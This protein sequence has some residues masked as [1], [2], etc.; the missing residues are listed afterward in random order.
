MPPE[1]VTYCHLAILSWTYTIHH[2]FFTYLKRLRYLT[3]RFDEEISHRELPAFRAA[4]IEKVGREHD[5]FHN[6]DSSSNSVYRYPLVQYKRIGRNPAIICLDAG[7][8][9]IHYL[10]QNRTWSIMVYDRP[11]ELCVKDLRLNQFNLQAWEHTFSFSI[12]DWLGLNQANYERFMAL[13]YEGDRLAFMERILRGNI[14][15]MA[16]GLDW[17]IDREVKVRIRQLSPMRL[18]HFKD[19]LLSAFDAD[20]DTNVFLP[21][22]IGL[23]KGVSVGFGVVT[24]KRETNRNGRAGQQD[25]NQN[26]SQITTDDDY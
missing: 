1:T 12:R 8:D 21:D 9:E 6:H 13:D 5:L 2:Y 18:Q 4:I 25:Y 17:F 3:V 15:S 10:F 24:R 22:L 14:L 11:M 26:Q 23:G 19:Q 7:V 16:K 20:F